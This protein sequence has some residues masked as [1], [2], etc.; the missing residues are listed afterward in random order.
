MADFD[1]MLQDL[2]VDLNGDG[3]PDARVPASSAVDRM[4]FGPM[5]ARTRTGLPNAEMRSSS[6]PTP[7][8]RAGDAVLK[9][10][11]IPAQFA[12][13]ATGVP[14]L[15]RGGANIGEGIARGDAWQVAG[16][17]GQSVLGALPGAS[18]L[19]QA[20]PVYN[21]LAGSIPR[22]SATGAVASVPLGIHEAQ[23]ATRTGVSSAMAADPEV[24]RLRNEITKRETER[25]AAQTQ[26]I[27]GLSSENA[28]LSRDK[29]AALIQKDIENL[30]IQI[31]KAE[32]RVREEY[33]RNAPF[34]ERYPGVAEA[35]VYGGMGIAG[36]MPFL[37]TVKRRTADY[38][39]GREPSTRL[40]EA[41]NYI[42]NA[43]LGSFA[44]FEGSGL[45]EQIDAA[46][47]DPGHPVREN[48]RNALTSPDYYASR[49][50]SAL[51]TGAGMSALGTE[52]GRLVTPGPRVQRGSAGGPPTGGDPQGGPP[53]G[54]P[55]QPPPNPQ[56]VPPQPPNG[57]PPGSPPQ[58]GPYSTYGKLP[59]VAKD[60]AAEAYLAER[61]LQGA[62]LSAK[63][64]ADGIRSAV[65]APVTTA[66]VNNTEAVVAQFVQ[67]NGRL[68]TKAEFNALRTAATLGL[69]GAVAY[70]MGSSVIESYGY[71]SP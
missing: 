39:T 4:P 42:K 6:L 55:Q 36:G 52:L 15:V 9:Y 23:A 62:P 22:L 5:T 38:F 58:W 69:T 28:Q 48:A 43:L 2:L 45:P 64:V 27:K 19:K 53:G 20:A 13:E 12:V 18:T 14:S 17:V 35:L 21:A 41:G 56:Q 66:R 51:L 50:P 10:G 16:G 33:S 63:G 54:Q 49:I 29:A 60:N 70:P 44:A 11:P 57:S 71:P 3:I 7:M 46:S 30:K 1:A 65:N 59:Q 25:N 34:R 68:P 47:F 37:E 32:E 61:L 31:A 26:N 8:E 67:Q 40:G 24:A